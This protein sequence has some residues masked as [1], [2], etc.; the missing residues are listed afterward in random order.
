MFVAAPV[1]FE[2]FDVE[3]DVVL[4]LVGLVVL[5]VAGCSHAFSKS[6]KILC[7]PSNFPFITR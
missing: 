1:L 5:L 4:L 6:F 7:T 3:F 2:T